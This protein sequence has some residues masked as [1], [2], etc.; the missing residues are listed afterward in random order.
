[1]SCLRVSLLVHSSLAHKAC[2]V[3]KTYNPLPPYQSSLLCLLL[4]ETKD[5]TITMQPKLPDQ[6]ELGLLLSCRLLGQALCTHAVCDFD[7]C[8]ADRPEDLGTTTVLFISPAPLWAYPF[9]PSYLTLNSRLSFK[10]YVPLRC[11]ARTVAGL[12]CS[13]PVAPRQA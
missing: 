8:P 4:R 5:S 10:I 6:P 9:R 12:A 11:K 13:R 1:M 2:N 7:C 3:T